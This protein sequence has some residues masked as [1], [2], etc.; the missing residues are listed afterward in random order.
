M[1]KLNLPKH[2]ILQGKERSLFNQLKQKMGEMTD[3]GTNDS[4]SVREHVLE[5]RK[6][7]SISSQRAERV[8][9]KNG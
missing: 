6:Q 5:R 2:Q 7:E 8:E 3:H 4:N 9:G 1:F